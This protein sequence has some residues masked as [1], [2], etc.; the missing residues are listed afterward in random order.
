MFSREMN[1]LSRAALETLV[2][3]KQNTVIKKD[4]KGGHLGDSVG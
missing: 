2:E 4:S 1:A 3:G